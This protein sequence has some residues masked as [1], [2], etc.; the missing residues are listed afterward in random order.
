[1]KKRIFVKSICFSVICVI[2]LWTQSNAIACTGI[3][4]R[5]EDNSVVHGRTMELSS[6]PDI[7]I[8]VIPRGYGFIGK[9]PIGDGLKYSAIY[10]A[11]GSIL[12]NDIVVQ[13]GINETGLA[14]ASFMF[15]TCAEYTPA[16]TENQKKGLSPVDFTN[17]L[18]TQ[19]AT[20]DEVREAV[21]NEVVVI[22][23]TVVD[24]WGTEAPPFH[25]MV[26]NKSGES[27]VIEPVGGK[28]IVHDNPFGVITNSPT[29]DWHMTNLR[30]YIPLDPNNLP[31]INVNDVTLKPFGEG[32][33]M[34]GL[35]GDFT[36]PSRFVRAIFFSTTAIPSKTIEKGV[37][38]VFHI[39]NNFDIPFGLVR[40]TNDGVVSIDH[41]VCTT[42]RDP[43]NLRYYY[44]SYDD[45]T[46]RMVQ[47]KQFDL[48][49]KE[50]KKL[51]TKSE[52]VIVDM[53]DK[54]K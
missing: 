30:N 44:K 45:Q 20:I 10:A 33:G 14:V 32:N 49:A 15:S 4:L 25:Y 24:G 22:T 18:L 9:T 38:Q 27:I 2:C 37:E 12:Y 17:W 51:N 42:A 48:E 34:F 21:K 1:M 46:I 26:Y 23:P 31:L 41:T 50:I 19:F 28:L 43:K 13:D 40:E 35:P 16:T 47:L 6:A 7:S 53:T 5:T 54:L 52:Q 8:V 39:L 36:P 11:V 3:M 29:F